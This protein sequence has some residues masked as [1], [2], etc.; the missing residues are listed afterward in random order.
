MSKKPKTQ[1]RRPI[2]SGFI[3]LGIGIFLLLADMQSLEYT[4]P[5]VIIIVGVALIIGAM[6]KSKKQ[7]ND[8]PPPPP[9][10]ASMNQ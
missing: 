1:K 4:W 3:Y 5:A 2:V 7:V 10:T 8:T 9:T 6:F